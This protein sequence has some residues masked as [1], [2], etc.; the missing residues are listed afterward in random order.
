MVVDREHCLKEVTGGPTTLQVRAAHA[1]APEPMP[2]TAKIILQFN[3][4]NCPKFSTED[5]ALVERMLV[6]QHRSRFCSAQTYQEHADQPNTFLADS[7]VLTQLKAKPHVMLAW[8]L[9][10][11][12][13]YQAAGMAQPRA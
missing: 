3:E 11:R 5:G 12:P 13:R 8:M 2:W 6:V 1:V 7:A 10:G 9:A 4:H